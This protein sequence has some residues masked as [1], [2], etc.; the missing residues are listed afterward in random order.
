MKWYWLG[1]LALGAF[2]ILSVP[3]RHCNSAV[4]ETGNPPVCPPCSQRLLTPEPSAVRTAAASDES[5]ATEPSVQPRQLMRTALPQNDCEGKN[6]AGYV[7]K[8][9]PTKMRL[10]IRQPDEPYR[11]AGR[12][13]ATSELWP[14]EGADGRPLHAWKSPKGSPAKCMTAIEPLNP[15]APL[16]KT[17]ACA[18]N[19]RRWADRKEFESHMNYDD[20]ERRKANVTF[21]ASICPPDPKRRL[22]FFDAGCRSYDSSTQWFRKHYPKGNEYQVYG[23]DVVGRYAPT[24]MKDKKA[25]FFHAAVWNESGFISFLMK[26]DLEADG[27]FHTRWLDQPIVP[28]RT[29]M[30]TVPT[31]P[32]S[33]FLFQRAAPEDFVVVKLDIEGAEWMVLE[34]MAKSGALS[35]VDELFIECHHGEWVPNWPTQHSLADCHRLFNTLRAHGIFAHEWY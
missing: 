15:S 19:N 8:R 7:T 17:D 18:R 31:V 26:R 21:L 23:L 5:M 11:K 12:C 29:K 22:L 25:A 24:F 13:E 4:E 30:L 14:L 1:L 35:L 28:L 3:L 2:L 9:Q 6:K 33:D 27:Y 20:T 32:F 10:G 16:M 34:D